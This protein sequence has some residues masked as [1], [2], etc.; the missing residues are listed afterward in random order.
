[1]AKAIKIPQTL[2]NA[3]PKLWV[4]SV[5][6]VRI[7]EVLA[8]APAALD[9][10]DIEGVHDMR[11]AVRRIRGA[12]KDFSQI[13]DQFPLRKVNRKF[14]V[15]ADSLG[16]VRDRDVAL[17]AL[18]D[19][20]DDAPDQMVK[21]GLGQMVQEYRAQRIAAF[22][23]LTEH[24]SAISLDKLKNK[25]ERA[26]ERSMCERDLVGVD[27]IEDAGREIICDCVGRFNKYADCF[28]H[29][30]AI[31]ELH[32]LR[33]AGKHLRYA[34]ELF[35]EAFGE[36]LTPFAVQVAEMQGH[37]GDLHDCDLWIEDMSTRLTEGKRKKRQM[38]PQRSAATWLLAEFTKKR[39]K[40]Y[41]AALGLWSQW[42]TD[43]FVETL[44]STLDPAPVKSK[45]ARAAA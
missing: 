38:N 29:P 18:R 34:M 43:D 2:A 22:D 19:A 31:N 1:M 14:K 6:R 32:R 17:E 24:L 25:T 12:I 3:D 15:L 33:I 10:S 16:Q 44:K 40:A 11:V 7:D 5:L 30:Y 23:D 36:K 13:S 4:V 28:Y 35:S 41:R 27:S 45:V 37:L 26:F 9:E 8:Y 21:D 39:T 20:S 42:E